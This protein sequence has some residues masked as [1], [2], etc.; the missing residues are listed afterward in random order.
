M[1]FATTAAVVGVD[2]A[3]MIAQCAGSK[4]V[5]VHES[6]RPT[7]TTP[8]S[9]S[10]PPPLCSSRTTSTPPDRNTSEYRESGHAS[11]DECGSEDATDENPLKLRDNARR[12]SSGCKGQKV[13]AYEMCPSPLHSKK[14]RIVTSGTSAGGRDWEPLV[15]QTLCDSCYSTYRKHGTFVRSVRTGE[16]WSRSGNGEAES[17]SVKSMSSHVEAL[18]CEKAEKPRKVPQQR[19]QR[20]TKRPRWG[21]ADDTSKGEDSRPKRQNRKAAV[22]SGWWRR[23]SGSAEVESEL[24]D[25]VAIL[26][27]LQ[28]SPPCPSMYDNAPEQGME[29]EAC[30][31]AVSHSTESD[32]SLP[33]STMQL[34]AEKDSRHDY[35][36]SS[37]IKV[38][39]RDFEEGRRRNEVDS[40]AASATGSFSVGQGTPSVCATPTAILLSKSDSAKG[41]DDAAQMAVIPVTTRRDESVCEPVK[42]S[43]AAPQIQADLF[44]PA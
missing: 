5:E 2:K 7:V 14:W 17:V 44:T 11:S 22:K 40:V 29:E 28:H 27:S 19:T 43:K 34:E 23:S 20:A 12:A 18:V 21:E 25:A 35:Q 41:G 31:H 4:R 24:L 10:P 32:S 38:E 1:S 42:L 26:R 8:S 3:A 39:T 13:C 15:G 33:P 36:G 6:R 37:E 9:P 30:P 16:G